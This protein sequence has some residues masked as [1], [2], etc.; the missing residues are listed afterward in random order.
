MF[1]IPYL[2]TMDLIELLKLLKVCYSWW[3][4]SDLIMIDRVHWTFT[5]DLIELLK[6]ADV[7]MIGKEKLT[8]FILN[9]LDNHVHPNPIINSQHFSFSRTLVKLD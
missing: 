4:L 2:P 8:K 7:I 9:P 3:V 1:S 5:M 6:L